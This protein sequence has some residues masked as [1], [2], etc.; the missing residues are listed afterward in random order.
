MKRDAASKRPDFGTLADLPGAFAGSLLIFWAVQTHNSC[1]PREN[2]CRL[3]RTS[4]ISLPTIHC[5]TNT[6]IQRHNITEI[7]RNKDCRGDEN[8]VYYRSPRGLH[9]LIFASQSHSLIDLMTVN[10][11][12]YVRLKPERAQS[13][14]PEGRKYRFS[15]KMSPS[16]NEIISNKKSNS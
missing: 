4:L 14:N 5:N 10:M 12:R 7:C 16:I 2:F 13:S 8:A 9:W 6:T 1:S 3:H 15:R 11:S